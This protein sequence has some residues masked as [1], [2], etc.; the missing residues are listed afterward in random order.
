[1]HVGENEQ[2]IKI[3]LPKGCCYLTTLKYHPK[4]S[5]GFQNQNIS[6]FRP[7]VESRVAQKDNALKDENSRLSCPHIFDLMKTIKFKLQLQNQQ[8]ESIGLLRDLT[9]TIMQDIYLGKAYDEKEQKLTIIK[10]SLSGKYVE[11]VISQ[12]NLN[13]KEIEEIKGKKKLMIRMVQ[14]R[15]TRLYKS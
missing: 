12:S 4:S 14:K 8:K 3:M 6:N 9:V 5:C 7:R 13:P 11:Q 15:M 2:D 10:Q 1:M